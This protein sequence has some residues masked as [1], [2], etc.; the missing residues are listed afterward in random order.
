MYNDVTRRY[1]RGQM[2]KRESEVLYVYNGREG[3]RARL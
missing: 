3:W 1:F 2:G